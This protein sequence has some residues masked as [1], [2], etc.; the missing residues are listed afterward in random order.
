MPKKYRT[1][2]EEAKLLQ[3]STISPIN[4]F[5]DI[6]V[7]FMDEIDDDGD[8]SNPTTIVDSPTNA[9]PDNAGD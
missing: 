3:P 8:I 5:P 7:D 4:V 9:C 1:P 2:V 6:H